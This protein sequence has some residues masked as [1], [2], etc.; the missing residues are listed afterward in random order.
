MTPMLP[1]DAQVLP[2]DGAPSSVAEWMK[3]SGLAEPEALR[4]LLELDAEGRLELRLPTSDPALSRL[5]GG[6]AAGDDGLAYVRTYESRWRRHRPL[7]DFVGARDYNGLL[8]AFERDLYLRRLA[9]HLDA[10][11]REA[12][13]LDAGCGVGRFT[14][15]LLERGLRVDGLDASASALKAAARHALAAGVSGRLSLRLGDVRR[16]PYE[17]AAFDA[18]LAL[19]L[20]CYQR[21]SE[22]SLAEL[23]RV[24][25]PGGL[26]IVSVEGRPGALLCDGRVGLEAWP[27]VNRDG[28]LDGEE[29]YVRYFTAAELRD[30]VAA[31]GARVLETRGTHYVPEGPLD[32]LVDEAALSEPAKRA[33]LMELEL[34]CET[35]PALAP[36]ARCWLAVAR[37]EKT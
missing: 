15:A 14:G 13:V 31:A 37:K 19:E 22:A 18:V 32:R 30:A 1:A 10:L 20:V 5:Y 23:L 27:R 17:D 26:L 29:L 34:S 35:E 24:L 16:M 2:A 33:A 9:P 3:G 36:L 6:G 12:R 21:P 4:R 28:E 8:K 11:P 7:F 25:K